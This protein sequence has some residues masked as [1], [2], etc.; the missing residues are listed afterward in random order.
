MDNH[1]R[2]WVL[3]GVVLLIAFFNA[4]VQVAGLTLEE[5]GTPVALGIILGLYL[6]KQFSTLGATGLAVRLSLRCA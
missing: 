3:V 2:P 5:L 4:G 6:G 1:V